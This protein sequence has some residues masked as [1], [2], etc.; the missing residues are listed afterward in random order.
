MQL[1]NCALSVRSVFLFSLYELIFFAPD[2]VQRCSFKA[3]M[4]AEL[5][6][7]IALVG[8]ICF[9]WIICHENKSR[10]RGTDLITIKYFGRTT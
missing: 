6:G 5:V 7:N 10:R 4:I 9:V 1:I 3:K 2:E 8:K